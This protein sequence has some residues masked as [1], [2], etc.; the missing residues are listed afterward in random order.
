MQ[1]IFIALLLPGR[2]RFPWSE[3]VHL[4]VISLPCVRAENR[5]YHMPNYLMDIYTM[6][7]AQLMALK[8]A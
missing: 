3:G 8:L 4:Y 2:S 1:K 6:N 5:Y 7:Y